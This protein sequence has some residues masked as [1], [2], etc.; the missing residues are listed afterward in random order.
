MRSLRCEGAGRVAIVELPDP[1]PGPEDVLVRIEASAICGSER[2]AFV[3]GTETNNGHEAC[4]RIVDAGASGLAVGARVG[5]SAIVGCGDCDRCRGGRETQCRRGFRMARS[6]GWHAD[7][8]S[9]PAS[10]IRELPEGAGPTLGA[11]L[12]GDTLGVPARALRRIPSGVGDAVLVI[13]LGP[14]GLGH[15]VVRRFA[16]ADVVAIEP[17]RYRRELAL[18]LGATEVLEPGE[19]VGVRPPLVIECTGRPE[20]VAQALEVVD[21]GGSVLQSG[22]FSQAVSMDP[23]TDFVNRE[24]TFAGSFYYASEDY[25]SM[26]ALVEDGLPLQDVCTHELDADDAQAAV[27]A[28]LEGETGKVVLRWDAAGS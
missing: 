23:A 7:M 8:A 13:G 22:Q 17:S 3:D 24:L 9:V 26:L 4:G 11:L 21:T 2:R 19:R 20:C 5:L 12:S 6:S 18:K 28:F 1:E 25:P 14:I 15:L 16:G 10:A 27:T